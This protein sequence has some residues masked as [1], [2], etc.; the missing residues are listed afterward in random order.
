MVLCKGS[1]A[2]DRISHGFWIS[3]DTKMYIDRSIRLAP[4]EAVIL[5]KREREGSS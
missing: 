3:I 5:S 2:R 1:L 4:P